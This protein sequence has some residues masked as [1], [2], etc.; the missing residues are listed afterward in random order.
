MLKHY[1]VIFTL[2]GSGGSYDPQTGLITLFTTKEG[3]F[4]KYQN[5]ANTI[6]HE[7]VHIGMEHSLVQKYNLAHGLKERIVDTFVFLMFGELLPE[8]TIQNMGD[9]G[10]DEHLRNKEDLKAL[11]TILEKHMK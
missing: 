1:E 8:Y 3:K 9:P 4:K 11:N 7:I 5:P 6:I 10:I 2:Y